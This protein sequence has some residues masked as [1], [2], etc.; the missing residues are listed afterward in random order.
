MLFILSGEKDQRI[1]AFGECKCTPTLMV[2]PYLDDELSGFAER[3]DGRVHEARRRV[4]CVRHQE[5]LPLHTTVNYK[6]TTPPLILFPGF[7]SGTP[8][9]VRKT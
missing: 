3:R 2:E 7:L 8:F 4:R 6:V 1:F 9:Q 5:R